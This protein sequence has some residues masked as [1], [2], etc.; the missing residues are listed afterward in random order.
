M[1]D[2]A[3]LLVTFFSCSPPSSAR[4]RP[5]SSTQRQQ[6]IA[7]PVDNLMTINADSTG[8]VFWDMTD[9]GIRL[10]VLDELAKRVNYTPTA[11]DKAVR[12]R[13]SPGHGTEPPEGF[14]G[15]QR[16]GPQGLQPA[17]RRHTLR[18]HAQ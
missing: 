3:F 14:P 4:K 18:Y 5:W 12:H 11:E 15:L 2:L 6:R 8:K 13:R 7:H 1:V 10:A 9:K 17:V 16:R